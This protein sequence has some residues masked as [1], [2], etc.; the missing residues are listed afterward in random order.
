MDE[1]DRIIAAANVKSNIKMEMR[2][3]NESEDNKK[4]SN[5]ESTN[6][7]DTDSL[8]YPVDPRI[9][10]LPNFPDLPHVRDLRE[11]KKN[12][13]DNANDVTDNDTDNDIATDDSQHCAVNQLPDNDKYPHDP[14][15]PGNNN[16]VVDY[17]TSSIFRINCNMKYTGKFVFGGDWKV[18]QF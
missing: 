12:D 6:G 14:D 17:G 7:D 1:D 3:H 11:D 9:P 18:H 16:T 15:I 5:D 10:I 8:G 2:D 4:S 13:H